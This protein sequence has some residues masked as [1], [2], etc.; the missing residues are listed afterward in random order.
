MADLRRDLIA[1]EIILR[2]ELGPFGPIRTPSPSRFV[3]E[4]RSSRVSREL[5]T[6]A[7]GKEICIKMSC[8][9]MTCEVLDDIGCPAGDWQDTLVELLESHDS[10]GSP[11]ISL[12]VTNSQSTN[13]TSKDWHRL[14]TL[15]ADN[16]Q[17]CIL[18]GYV[19]IIH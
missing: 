18:R 3:N 6:V 8:L 19:C 1:N 9:P 15:P 11:K 12:S 14:N 2:V 4:A 10:V 13:Y 5:F 16:G 7:K 17:L